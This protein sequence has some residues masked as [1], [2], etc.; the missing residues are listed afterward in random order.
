MVCHAN[1]FT[2]TS[3][4]ETEDGSCVNEASEEPVAMARARTI[5]GEGLVDDEALWMQLIEAADPVL[6]L[7][8][9]TG[10]NAY[11]G[12]GIL[13]SATHGVARRQLQTQSFEIR[14]IGTLTVTAPA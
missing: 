8:I 10:A 5:S 6:T 9:T 14:I 2:I 11:A 13:V 4:I 1:S 7:A 3:S 12:S